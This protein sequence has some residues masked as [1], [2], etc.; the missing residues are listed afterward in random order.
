M[1]VGITEILLG[2]NEIGIKP[3]G[4]SKFFDGTVPVA[5]QDI[6]SSQVIVR[7]GFIGRFQDG[8]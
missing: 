3:G 8:V 6:G 7:P 5:L 2:E 4:S 1:E